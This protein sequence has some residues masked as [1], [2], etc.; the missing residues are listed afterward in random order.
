MS[1]RPDFMIE[2]KWRN[3]HVS[4]DMNPEDSDEN[5]D[6]IAITHDELTQIGLN[7]KWRFNAQ[8]EKFV[9]SIPKVEL[10]VHFGEDNKI[11]FNQLI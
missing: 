9:R 3:S 11:H 4:G 10:H 6:L 2:D 7:E 8:L 5:E 1:P